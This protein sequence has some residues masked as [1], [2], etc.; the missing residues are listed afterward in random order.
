MIP[1]VMLP[2]QAAQPEPVRL[3]VEV[4]SV[5]DGR[6]RSAGASRYP[7]PRAQAAVSAFGGGPGG[8]DG[9][10]VSDEELEAHHASDVSNPAFT[11]WMPM[12]AAA[13][14]TLTRM[15]ATAR[16]ASTATGR[17]NEAAT[18]MG[19]LGLLRTGNPDASGDPDDDDL[20]RA[21]EASLADTPLP[22]RARLRVTGGQSLGSSQA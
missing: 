2:L 14:S 19:S 20:Q 16:G 1:V 13:P 4:S 10:W 15:P 7:L 17:G 21:I 6:G 22:T 11:T 3:E 8:G 5:A 9:D 12:P 18:A